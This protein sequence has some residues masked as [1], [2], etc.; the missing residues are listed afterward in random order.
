MLWNATT[1]TGCGPLRSHGVEPL[2][3]GRHGSLHGL[4]VVGR[5]L[6]ILTRGRVER[7]QH[8]RSARS[9]LVGERA[10]GLRDLVSRARHALV[11][12]AAPVRAHLVGLRDL[13][14]R[15]RHAYTRERLS[16]PEVGH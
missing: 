16:A 2:R 8:G 5:A 4:G 12:F 10:V 6:D 11:K 1:L 7:R 15:A 13:V 14:S 9:A 3:T